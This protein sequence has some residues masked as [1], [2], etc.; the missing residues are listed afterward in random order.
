VLPLATVAIKHTATGIATTRISDERGR[1]FFL[2]LQTGQCEIAVSF[3]S[4]ATQTR[5]VTL[6]IGRT[7]DLEFTLNLGEVNQEVIVAFAEPQLQSTTAEISDVIENRQVIEIPLNGRNF[8]SLA[9]LS[10]A[11]VIPPGGT[12]G[13]AL[14]QAGPLPNVGGQRSGHNIYLLDRAKVT[15]ELF[16]NLV[17]NPSVDSIQEFKIQKSMYAAEFGG[18]ASALINVATRSG[19]N[20][21][22]GSLFEFYRNDAFD[23]PNYFAKNSPVPPLSQHQFGGAVGGPLKKEQTFF[24]LSYEGLRMNRTLTRTFSVPSDAVRNGD[25]SGLDAIC[26]PETIPTVGVCTPF[27]NNTI[28]TPRIDPIAQALLAKVPHANAAGQVRNLTAQERST[29]DIDQFSARVDHHVSSSDQIFG[30][31]S[32]FDAHE[33]QPFGTS[34]LQE[35]LVPGFGRTLTTTTRN[36]ALSHTHLF[37]VSMIN[38][39]RFGWMKVAGGHETVNKGVD[40]AAQTGLQGVTQDPNEERWARKISE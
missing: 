13:D 3:P 29:R 16:N 19:G 4:F 7:L 39:L 20:D 40:F 32:M 21:F 11:V 28:P 31:F 23:T 37:G 8:L 12:R 9:Q 33:L 35:T 10:D 22:H 27:S 24:F 1:F 15:D 34:S 2:A 17:I 18:K 14:Q 25:F 30:R 26:D 36:L 38:E 6:E 5:T